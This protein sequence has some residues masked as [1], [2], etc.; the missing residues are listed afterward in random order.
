MRRRKE[1]VADINVARRPGYIDVTATTSVVTMPFLN[2]L[3]DT[4]EKNVSD[5]PG[6]FT[7]VMLE[8]IAPRLDISLIEAY[9]I[10]RRAAEL[11]IHRTQIAYLVTGRPLGSVARFMETVARN[12]GILLKF[13][14]DRQHAMNWLFPQNTTQPGTDTPD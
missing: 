9:E 13:F 7:L 11:G 3:M 2:H 6:Q 4:V 1:P 8:I 10:W 5:R 12:R 14:E